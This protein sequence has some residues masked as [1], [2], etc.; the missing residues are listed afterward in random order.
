MPEKFLDRIITSKKKEIEVGKASLPQDK[1]IKMLRTLA[2]DAGLKNHSA[3]KR[4]FKDSINIPGRTAL[5]AEIK[6]SSP[7]RG[8]LKKDFDPVK[9]AVQYQ[10]AG[11]SAISVLTDGPF[12]GGHNSYVPAVKEATQLPVLRK[13]FLIDEYQIYQ[14]ALIE[15]DCILLIADI[16]NKKKL[17]TFLSCAALVNVEALVEVHTE[18]SLDTALSSRAESIGINNRNLKDFSVD[19]KTTERLIKRIPKDKIIVSE[20]GIKT[21]EDVKFLKSLGVNAVLIGEAFMQAE[22]ITAKIKEMM[23]FG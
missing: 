11:A 23:D 20:S 13:D 17:R 22:D 15:A 8:I 5:I 21:S 7:S 4:S 3:A 9:I 14:S 12:F 10:S 2:P 6:K 18:A 16:L 1:I 19:I